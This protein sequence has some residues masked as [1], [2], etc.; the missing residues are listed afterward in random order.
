MIVSFRDKAA[1]GLFG[2]VPSRRLPP[3]VQRTA[4]RKLKMLDAATGLL[5]L[6]SPWGNR[7]EPLH[8]DREGQYSVRI[9]DQ[10]RICF[11]WEAGQAYDVEI[12]DY[13]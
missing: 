7:L 1:A 3:E 8:G 6:R 12:V 11:R 10:W 2:G 9:N 13:H 4:Y 5:D